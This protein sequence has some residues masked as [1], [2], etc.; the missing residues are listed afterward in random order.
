MTPGAA[1]TRPYSAEEAR[2]DIAAAMAEHAGTLRAYHDLIY[3]QRHTWGCTRFEGVHVL[4]TPQDLWSYHE[5]MQLLKPTLVIETG[6]AHGGSA[7][8]FAR[9]MERYD[10]T[11]S[12]ITVDL[13]DHPDKPEHEQVVYVQ[14][15]SLD[16]AHVD[17]L[18]NLSSVRQTMVVLDSAHDTAHVLRE[19]DAYAGM[20]SVGQLLVVEDTNLQG[21]ADALAQWLPNHPEFEPEMLCERWLVSFFPGGWLRR[22]A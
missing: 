9:Q 19:L 21:V 5:W 13:D 1:V 2:A 16:P 7:L 6:T 4:K 18:R 8:Y 12:V 20:V 10:R 22:V 17:W 15:D 11:G 14:G 3:H